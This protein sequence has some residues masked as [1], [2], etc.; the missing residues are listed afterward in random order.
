MRAQL[1]H[2]SAGVSGCITAALQG[3]HSI[4]SQSAQ[5]ITAVEDGKFRRDVGCTGLDANVGGV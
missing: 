4:L 5:S 3:V 2:A 1:R